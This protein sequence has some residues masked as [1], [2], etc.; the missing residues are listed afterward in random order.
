MGYRWRD[1]TDQRFGILTAKWPVGV[2]GKG[3]RRNAVW[4]CVCDCGVVKPLMG[5][6]LRAGKAKSCNCRRG[7]GRLPKGEAAFNLTYRHYYRSAKDREIE[8]ALT[9]QQFRQLCES[10]C[11]YCKVP[12]LQIAGSYVKKINGAFTYNGVDRK[13]SSMGYTV[14]NSLPCCWICNRAKGDMAFEDFQSYLDRFRKHS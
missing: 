10:E 9:K 2:V 5:I 13:D 14:Q 6:V 4:L 11:F 8:F 12:P 3:W 7:F 1:L